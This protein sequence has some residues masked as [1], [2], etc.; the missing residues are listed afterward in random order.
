[1]VEKVDCV[2]IG[3]GVVGLAL[4]R[5]Q[6]LRGREVVIL[7]AENAFGTV[8]SSR[9][10][11]VIH[12]GV[13]YP[14]GSLKARLCVEG[15]RRMYAYLS[16]RGV[17]HKN[18]TKL[19][20]ASEKAEEEGLREVQTKASA[21]GVTLNWL[22]GIEAMSLEPALQCSAALI[23]PTTGILDSHGLMLALLGDAEAHG[24]SLALLSPALGGEVTGEGIV[25]RVG[26]AEPMEILAH[27]VINSA[28]HGAQA[29]SHALSG[30]PQDT[31]PP[32]HMAKGNYFTL[33][34]KAP[35]ER[36]VYPLPRRAS[37]GLHYTRDL[38][39]QGRFGPDVE[40]VSSMDYTVDPTRAEK[41]Y[42]A[43]RR[44]WPELPDGALL[45]AYAGIRPKIQGPG[46]DAVD[47]MILGPKDHGVSGYVALYG[48]ES[49][50][51]TSCLALADHVDA[52]LSS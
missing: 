47:F 44:Y 51:L 24:A 6:A 35:F 3:A 12:A 2:V 34:G 9:N 17:A 43:I 40:W 16:E 26:G 15:N 46:E 18:V 19:I 30:L 4:A 11:E 7:E 45:P 38:A 23:S 1:M 21:S 42:D 28:G 20:V 36:L 32:H 50:G 49:P 22:S 27:T 5:A 52:L 39:G 10:S 48:I 14:K 29:F 37:L 33:S 13:Y 31:I 41:F 8:T 25:L